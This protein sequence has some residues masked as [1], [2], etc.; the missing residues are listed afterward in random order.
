MA[1]NSNRLEKYL[2]LL[3]NDSKAE[4]YFSTVSHTDM[5]G[6]DTGISF[7]PITVVG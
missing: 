4:S 5:W 3:F 2:P 7:V 6:E 1:E